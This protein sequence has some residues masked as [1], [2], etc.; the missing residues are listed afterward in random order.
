M[1][2]PRLL[3]LSGL[4][5]A[6]IGRNVMF[7]M[8]TFVFGIMPFRVHGHIGR[9]V[10][11]VHDD[12]ILVDAAA[13][14]AAAEAGLPWI[15]G[16]L[17]EHC[18]PSHLIAEAKQ[19]P[20]GPQHKIMMRESPMRDRLLGFCMQG[21]DLPQVTNTVDLDPSGHRRLGSS[22]GQD[23]L[24]AAHPRA[25]RLTAPWGQARADHEGGWRGADHDG[26]VPEDHRDL[27][28]SHS[29][30]S[31]VPISR[32]VAGTA[33]F[34]TDPSSSACDPWGRLWEAPNVMI[35]DSS[36]FPTG[37]GYGPTLTLVALSLRNSRA[38]AG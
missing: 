2:T 18:S 6:Q 3:L 34:G 4:T 29:E 19:Y 22:R 31:Q 8:Q 27:A 35:A 21:D 20:W 13:R 37:S 12:H 11:H 33:R 36:L 7:H 32:H 28:T 1:E 38:F 5:N 10:T 23:D 26:N 24:P 15:K 30:I 25:D 16:G 17:V 14:A 9:S